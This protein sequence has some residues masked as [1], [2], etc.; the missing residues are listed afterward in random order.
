MVVILITLMQGTHSN[1]R[2][3]REWCFDGAQHRLHRRWQ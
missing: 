3:K 1:Y 2:C